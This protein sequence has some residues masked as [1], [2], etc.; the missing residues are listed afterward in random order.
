[1][2]LT[3][4]TRP[5]KADGDTLNYD[6]F[7]LSVDID[8]SSFTVALW[9]TPAFPSGKFHIGLISSDWNAVLFVVDKS[10][11]INSQKIDNIMASF[12]TIED[13]FRRL[14]FDVD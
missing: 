4:K 14:F 10:F 5:L 1:M 6:Q 2:K 3:R 13:I 12:D 7:Y 11:C 8:A 9:T